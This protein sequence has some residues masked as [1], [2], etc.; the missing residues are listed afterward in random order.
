MV[1]L[2]RKKQFQ[3]PSYIVEVSGELERHGYSCYVVGGAVRDLLLGLEPK[4]WDLTTSATVGQMEEVFLGFQ[5]LPTGVDH[6]TLTVRVPYKNGKENVEITTF[7]KDGMYFDGRR[8]SSV[9]Y[10]SD[11]QEDLSRRDFTINTLAYR[12]TEDVVY[13]YPG[14]VNDLELGVIRLVGQSYDEK[15]WR[16]IEDPLR[17]LRAVRFAGQYGFQI[18]PETHRAIWEKRYLLYRVSVERI[19]DELNKILMGKFVRYGLDSMSVLGLLEIISPMHKLLDGMKQSYPHTLNVLEHSIEVVG[20]LHMSKNDNLEL[21]LAGF[22]HDIGKSLTRSVGEDGRI[23]F[24]EH[25][26]V[27]SSIAETELKRLRYP[28]KTIGRVVWLIENH[29]ISGDLSKKGIRRLLCRC[30]GDFEL[31]RDC[32]ELRKADLKGKMNSDFEEEKLSSLISLENRIQEVSE[33]KVPVNHSQLDI[34]G[35]VIMNEFSL[36]PGKVIRNGLRYL[37]DKVLDGEVENERQSLIRSLHEGKTMWLVV[38]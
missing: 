15:V 14:G 6:G 24:Y 25:E 8:P 23:H 27:G 38:D 1:G 5:L 20:Q 26:R 7:R 21:L 36:T 22:F 33:E 16:L 4:D 34:D 32:V 2:D 29:M 9:E 28:N 37:M 30:N 18:E 19:Q 10:T 11:L 17:M 35:F 12:I 13:Y 31:V 3:I